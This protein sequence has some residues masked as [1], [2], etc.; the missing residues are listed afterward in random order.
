M[1]AEVGRVLW[2]QV[3][4]CL[5]VFAQREG[6]SAAV[7]VE[8][9]DHFGLAT[10]PRAAGVCF[11]RVVVLA[12]AAVVVAEGAPGGLLASCLR[13]NQI[14]LLGAMTRKIDLQY[15]NLST[16]STAKVGNNGSAGFRT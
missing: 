2:G 3:E 8:A 12:A 9:E 7:A 6:A 10:M 11:R 14:Y 13:P 5:A 16:K 15:D 1:E 4:V